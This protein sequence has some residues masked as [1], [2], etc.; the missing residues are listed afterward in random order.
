MDS[1]C[2]PQRR[3]LELHA[4]GEMI[5]GI[6]DTELDARETSRTTCKVSPK[7]NPAAATYRGRGA[8]IRWDRTLK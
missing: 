1:S 2:L 5:E 6:L 7:A 3:L 4:A 8:G